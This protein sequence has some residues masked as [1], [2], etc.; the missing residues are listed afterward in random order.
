[1]LRDSPNYLRGNDRYEG[2]AIDLMERIAKLEG[3]K[4]TL[5]LRNDGKNGIFNAQAGKWTG[6][7]GDVL[8]RVS[9]LLIFDII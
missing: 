3:F 6:M 9:I 4:Y 5:V 8:E 1:M 7:I 2:Y